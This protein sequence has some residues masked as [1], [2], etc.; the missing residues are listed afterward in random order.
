M[1]RTSPPQSSSPQAIVS[2]DTGGA[3]RVYCDMICY[4]HSHEP[5]SRVHPSPPCWERVSDCQVPSAGERG[6][7]LLAVNPGRRSL[8]SLALG[9]FIWP[10]QGQKSLSMGLLNTPLCPAKKI[11]DMIS[12]AR[13]SV[14]DRYCS[15]VLSSQGGRDRVLQ[16]L[17]PWAI[18]LSPLIGPL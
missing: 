4:P 12:S 6:C 11:C 7:V 2:L 15:G 10:L 3:L 1:K 8:R 13:R 16:P 9:Y 17:L 14:D 5:I 18:L